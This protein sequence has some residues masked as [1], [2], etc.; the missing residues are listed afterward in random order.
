LAVS[1]RPAQAGSAIASSAMPLRPAWSR[2]AS[3]PCRSST[4]IAS[5]KVAVV[6]D[7]QIRVVGRS[8]RL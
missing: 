7:R 4:C 6:I 8:T 1:D 3:L 5:E 2:A